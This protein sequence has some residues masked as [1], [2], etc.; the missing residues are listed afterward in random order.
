[1]LEEIVL[2][3]LDRSG[4]RRIRAGEE[5]THN[6]PAGLEVGG[7]AERQNMETF[8]VPS[9]EICISNGFEVMY[10]A[11]GCRG[12]LDWLSTLGESRY[13]RNTAC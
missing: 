9:T 5:G 8:V 10:V 6:G 13:H 7:R 12:A 2:L 3:L 11:A 1:L 4:Y